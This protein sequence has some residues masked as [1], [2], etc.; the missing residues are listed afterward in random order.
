MTIYKSKIGRGLLIPLAVL[1][2]GIGS[3]MAYKGVWAGTGIIILLCIFIGHMFLTTYYQI[4]GS[5][6]RIKS[7]FLFNM[8]LP[9][10]TIRKISE[11]QNPI[12]SPALSLDRIE[13]IYNRF[14]SVI[15]SPN[16][17]MSFIKALLEVNPDIEVR[18][19]NKEHQV[20]F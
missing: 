17:K 19:K 15:I 6:L 20:T 11:T 4:E 3:F 5:T 7:G 1:L 14:D 12:S 18:L 13:L 2:I 16:N 9:I 8:T 10:E